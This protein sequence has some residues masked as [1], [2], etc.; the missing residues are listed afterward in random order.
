MSLEFKTY[1]GY[2]PDQVAGFFEGRG[3][4]VEF[5]GASHA[6]L[7]TAESGA[8]LECIDGRF[9]KRE[10]IKKHGPKIPGGIHAV[11]A[12]KTGGDMIGFNSAASEIANLGF[13]AGTH[14]HCGLFKLWSENKLTAVK[15]SLALPEICTRNFGGDL[16]RWFDLNS[17]F[18]GGKNFRVPDPHEEE[19]VTF[20]PHSNLTTLARKDRFSYDHWFMQ[21]LGISGSKAMYLLA[22]TVEQICNHRKIEILTS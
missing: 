14:E 5:V 11:A 18:W 8:A 15:H 10:N 7:V 2:N 21:L 4:N 22:E 1:P 17:R 12:L 19:A 20:N 9:G 6:G 16:S 3:W 13:R